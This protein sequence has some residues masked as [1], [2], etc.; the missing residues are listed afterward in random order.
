M[1][2]LC[3]FSLKNLNMSQKRPENQVIN[4]NAINLTVDLT[5]EDSI[6]KLINTINCFLCVMA[7]DCFCLQALIAAVVLYCIDF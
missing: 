7:T 2:L 1:W 3:T 5:A 4:F 6:H